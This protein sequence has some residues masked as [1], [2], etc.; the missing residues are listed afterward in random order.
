MPRF[1]HA[2]AGTEAAGWFVGGVVVLLFGA[3]VL[4]TI[5]LRKLVA[6]ER[7]LSALVSLRTRELAQANERLQE[8]SLVDSV[9]G[10]AN[11]RHFDGFLEKEWRRAI[12]EH[13]FLSILFV[14]FDC[15]KPFTTAYGQSDT[16]QCLKKISG[17]L[18]RTAKRPGDLVARYGAGEFAVVLYGA[19]PSHAR[20]LADEMR[21]DVGNLRIPHKDSVAGP[22]VSVSVGVATTIPTLD[23]QP[24]QLVGIADSQL[25]DARSNGYNQVRA[26]TLG[27]AS[28]GGNA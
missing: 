16:D 24:E 4:Y 26:T 14:D 21:L 28:A 15:F 22:Y 18:S 7:E 1:A 23:A 13:S 27:Y 19:D 2:H 25:F 6:R 5:R 3:L 9:T 11:R 8:M 20:R 17:I 12:R 10:V